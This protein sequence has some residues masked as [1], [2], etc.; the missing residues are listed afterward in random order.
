VQET[1]ETV[2]YQFDLHY[3]GTSR[4]EILF[5]EFAR[6]LAP[7]PPDNFDAILCAVVLH[8]M[9]E[10]RD[11]CLHGPATS[12]MLLNLAEFQLAWSCWLP[13][14][15]RPVDIEVD[16]VVSKTQ[17]RTPRAIS[18]FSGGV[19]SSFTL[20][21]NSASAAKRGFDVDTVLLVHGFDVLLSNSD[22]LRELVERTAPIRALAGVQLRIVRTNSK[23]LGLQRWEHSFGAQLAACMHL[24]SAE[25]CFALMGSSEPYDA[26][27]L[28]W[29][30]NPVTDHLLSGANLRIVHDGAAFSRTAKI[31]YLSRFPA[32]VKSLKVC[33]EGKQQGRNC[34]VCEKCVRTQLNFL[35]VGVKNPLCFERPLDLRRIRD[36]RLRN[37][38]LVAEFRSIVE[39]AERRNIDEEWLRLLRRRLRRRKRI[40]TA[41]DELRDL[42]AKAGLLETARKVRRMLGPR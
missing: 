24:C 40:W 39:Y 31:A 6:E 3:S 26:L 10:Q 36:I 34:G 18:A 1:P 4:A 23:E 16:S 8:A 7:A 20:I 33:W 32:A 15:Y 37:D 2:R 25:F 42:F 14:V 35:A 11:I 9:A 21:R 17:A 22:D 13:A 5:Y 27:V 38:A 41:K 12:V 30:S 28:P 29:G 19:D